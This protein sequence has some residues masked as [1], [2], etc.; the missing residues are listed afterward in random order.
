[1]EPRSSKPHAPLSHRRILGGDSGM[2]R[3]RRSGDARG[4]ILAI[5]LVL[6]VLLVFAVMLRDGQVSNNLGA[7]IEYWATGGR[8]QE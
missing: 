4:N 1:M 3:G 7:A 5:C 2:E 6:L 8:F